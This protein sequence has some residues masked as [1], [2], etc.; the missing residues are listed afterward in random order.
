M[1][2]GPEK[3]DKVPKPDILSLI[4]DVSAK[5]KFVEMLEK[6]TR[7]NRNGL[8]SVGKTIIE[9]KQKVDNILNVIS[10][11]S[12][13]IGTINSSKENI[14]KLEL[15]LASL[16][17]DLKE[18]I[19]AG[20]NRVLKQVDEFKNTLD[21]AK[22]EIT[23]IN[24]ALAVINAIDTVTGVDVSAVTVYNEFK[25]FQAKN[26]GEMDLL[27]NKLQA[28]IE[29]VN[30]SKA[31]KFQIKLALYGAILSIIATLITSAVMFFAS[32]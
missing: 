1:G 5:I 3:I 17:N 25:V 19:N 20:D 21:K 11:L 7:D 15:S 10:K 12:N 24:K 22:E 16:A 26:T 23:E 13:S 8:T 28:L 14:A 30:S 2:D 6:Q 27:N 29:S 9:V 18:L 31:E 4:I 32:K